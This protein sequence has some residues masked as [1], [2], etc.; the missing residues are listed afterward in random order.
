MI[1]L[2]SGI[3]ILLGIVVGGVLLSFNSWNALA[4]MPTTMSL[5]LSTISSDN[6][7]NKDSRNMLLLT[8]PNDELERVI[9]VFKKSFLLFSE[10]F[11]KASGSVKTMG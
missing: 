5:I 1:D 2:H 11:P 10:F 3:I 4:A 7:F 9:N 6:E 8:L